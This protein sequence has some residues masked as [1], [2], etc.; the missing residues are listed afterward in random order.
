MRSQI[1]VSMD[2]NKEIDNAKNELAKVTAEYNQ[3]SAQF[4]ELCGMSGIDPASFDPTEVEKEIVRFNSE[5]AELEK[6]AEE[7]KAAYDAL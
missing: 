3:C 6:K 4:K 1:E 5:I 7:L 2:L